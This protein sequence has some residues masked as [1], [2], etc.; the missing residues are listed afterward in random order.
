M[1]E[2]VAAKMT[3]TGGDEDCTL[4]YSLR[5]WRRI[6]DC[7]HNRLQK[8][9]PLL[10]DIPWVRVELTEGFYRVFVP[11]MLIWRDEYTRKSGQT[12]ANVAQSRAEQSRTDQKESRDDASLSG[13]SA[14][15]VASRSPPHDFKVTDKMREWATSQRPDV[16]IDLETQI[17][18]LHEF[19]TSRTDWEATWK[20]WILGA[21]PNRLNQRGTVAP[22]NRSQE[23]IGLAEILRISQQ[24]EESESEFLNRVEQANLERIRNLDG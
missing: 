14:N 15:R 2:I 19:P 24:D 6:L 20:K 1:L 9:L 21:N 17:F 13:V 7:N 5:E 16:D 12:P 10:D 23:M 3:P 4:E 8:Y 11:K 18:M 22:S